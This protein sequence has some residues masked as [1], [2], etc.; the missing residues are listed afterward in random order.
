MQVPTSGTMTTARCNAHR[1]AWL[2]HAHLLVAR[3]VLVGI[4]G[5]FFFAGLGVFTPVASFH[6]SSSALYW[7]RPRSA[8]R[9]SPESGIWA[10]AR[11]ND[12]GCWLGLPCSYKVCD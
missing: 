8:C 1:R 7:L 10:R 11:S 12:P 9:S 2:A 3:V 4:F 6:T 5:Q